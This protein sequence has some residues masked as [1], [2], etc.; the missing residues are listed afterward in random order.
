MMKWYQSPSATK[1]F[2]KFLWHFFWVDGATLRMLEIS[3]L[4]ACITI[5]PILSVISLGLDELREEVLNTTTVFFSCK[6]SV[7]ISEIASTT[8]FIVVN[9]RISTP[10][11]CKDS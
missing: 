5:Q 9:E 10:H 8:Q 11:T 6:I 4:S 2:Y 7:S 3:S 1:A